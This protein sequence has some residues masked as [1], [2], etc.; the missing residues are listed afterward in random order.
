MLI[1]MY[2]LQMAAVHDAITHNIPM[3]Q[4]KAEQKEYDNYCFAMSLQRFSCDTGERIMTMMWIEVRKILPVQQVVSWQD[5][6][7]MWKRLLSYLLTHHQQSA[8]N[9]PHLCFSC[10]FLDRESILTTEKEEGQA[11]QYVQA[12]CISTAKEDRFTECL[13]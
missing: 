6:M 2:I 13:Y 12:N 10:D 4:Q 11:F 1:E 3:V 5:P 8:Q 7:D 9:Y